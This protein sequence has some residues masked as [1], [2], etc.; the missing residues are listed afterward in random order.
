MHEEYQKKE[1]RQG[2]RRKAESGMEIKGN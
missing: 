2:G 1:E